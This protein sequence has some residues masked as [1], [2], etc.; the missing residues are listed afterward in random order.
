MHSSGYN[1]TLFTKC[2]VPTHK[3]V[4]GDKAF[5]KNRSTSSEQLTDR[6]TT[7]NLPLAQL[8]A[9]SEVTS[10]QLAHAQ[11][12]CDLLLKRGSTKAAF[13]LNPIY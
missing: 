1:L 7:E 10:M 9:L 6:S 4:Y 5:A 11:F 8:S 12:L 2:Q 13:N 3:N